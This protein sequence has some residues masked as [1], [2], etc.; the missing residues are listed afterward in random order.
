MSYFAHDFGDYSPLWRGMAAEIAHPYR[1]APEEDRTVT[2][3]SRA[4]HCPQ[5]HLPLGTTSFFHQDPSLTVPRK[6]QSSTHILKT[7]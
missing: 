1:P 7:W 6:T 3:R 5:E 4:G 2:G